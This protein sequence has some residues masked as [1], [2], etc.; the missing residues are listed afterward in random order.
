MTGEKEKTYTEE[1]VKEIRE[2]LYEEIKRRDSIIDD[3]K[4]NNEILLKTAI[5]NKER[6]IEM[7]EQAEK[8]KHEKPHQKHSTEKNNAKEKL[9]D[10]P[11]PDKPSKSVE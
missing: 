10:K 7:K 5:K 3:L 9:S 2:M 11:K 8:Q 1:E 4:K 6:D